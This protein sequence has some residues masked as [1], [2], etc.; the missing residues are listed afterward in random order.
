MCRTK[1]LI[2][3]ICKARD[4]IRTLVKREYDSVHEEGEIKR[5]LEVLFDRMI[6]M[7]FTPSALGDNRIRT[8]G[9]P[10]RSWRMVRS[11]CV[12]GNPTAW[13][14]PEMSQKGRYGFKRE[15]AL[16]VFLWIPKKEKYGFKTPLVFKARVVRTLR[17]IPL[18]GRHSTRRSEGHLS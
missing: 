6:R 13:K 7:D 8:T 14:L 3:T 18:E 5:H 4:L 9:D 17:S 11:Y 16:A 1:G 2:T 15:K 12:Q 10:E